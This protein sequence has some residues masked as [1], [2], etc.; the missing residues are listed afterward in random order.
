MEIGTKVEDYRTAEIYENKGKYY[1][2][3]DGRYQNGCAE[4]LDLARKV[5]DGYIENINMFWAVMFAAENQNSRD[6]G[7]CVVT[8]NIWNRYVQPKIDAELNARKVKEL[9]AK[10]DKLQNQ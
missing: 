4:S 10:L 8:R 9:Q 6:G 7:G 5:A 2:K 1:C 3:V